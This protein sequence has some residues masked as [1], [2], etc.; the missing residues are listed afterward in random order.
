MNGTKLS[1][2]AVG[3]FAAAGHHLLMQ[4]LTDHKSLTLHLCRHLCITTY[5]Y[6][7]WCCDLRA[8]ILYIPRGCGV[9][10]A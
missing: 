4:H 8:V 6:H 7:H 10:S 9:I 2:M 3:F 5:L 1:G